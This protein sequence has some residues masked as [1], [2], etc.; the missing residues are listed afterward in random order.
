MFSLSACSGLLLLY[1]RGFNSHSCVNDN[2]VSSGLF[3]CFLYVLL[4]A[5][6]Y[7]LTRHITTVLFLMLGFP[8][9]EFEFVILLVCSFVSF[10]TV[11]S[12]RSHFVVDDVAVLLLPFLLFI[13][14]LRYFSQA[15]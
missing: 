2:I 12:F 14:I 11:A 5:M 3:C 15:R 1:V 4:F 8:F 6:V 7:I 13:F 10:T 9:R